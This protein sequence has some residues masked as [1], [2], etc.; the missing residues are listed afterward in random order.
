[1]TNNKPIAVDYSNAKL[2]VLVEEYITMQRKDFTFK[3]VCSFVLY[4]AMEEERTAGAGLYE[5]DLLAP[6]DC[7]RVRV[8]LEKI[9]HEGR[10]SV[11]GEDCYTKITN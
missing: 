3:G 2:R 7:N 5:S 4:R 10:L 11:A 6:A 1:M 9:G 8:I